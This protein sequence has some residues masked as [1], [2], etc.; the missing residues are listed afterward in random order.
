MGF[1]HSGTG[2]IVFENG[3]VKLIFNSTNIQ[4]IERA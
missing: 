2:V 3:R 4:A 1:T